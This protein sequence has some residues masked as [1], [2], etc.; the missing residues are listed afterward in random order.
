M[1]GT[2]RIKAASLILLAVA[3]SACVG[4]NPLVHSNAV[5]VRSTPT[6]ALATSEYGDSCTT[7]C[8]LRLRTSRGG[9]I[10]VTH[11]GYEPAE[12]SIGTRPNHVS[13]AQDAA[14]VT[15][16]ASEGDVVT[17]AF[18]ALEYALDPRGYGRRLD[19]RRVHVD[20]YPAGAL[21]PMET[22]HAATDSAATGVG[23]PLLPPDAPGVVRLADEEV[24]SIL[25]APVATRSS[26][27]A[28]QA[29]EVETTSNS[30]SH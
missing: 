25:G 5:R 20:L 1:K 12:V 30:P 13:N 2:H 28:T 14:R 8:R 21:R 15:L 7:P 16:A 9:V 4:G 19:T 29:P 3:T 24:D 27:F 23:G 18:T 22:Q 6:G 17:L 10:R 26:P 11:Q